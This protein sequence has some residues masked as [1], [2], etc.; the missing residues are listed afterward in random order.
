MPEV[1]GDPLAISEDC[2]EFYRLRDARTA[3]YVARTWAPQLSVGVVI[4]SAAS[5][6]V[7][8]QHLLL[9]LANMLARVHRKIVFE[10]PDPNRPLGV[11]CIIPAST[12]GEALL[13]STKVIDP[14][15]SF[16]LGEVNSCDVTLGIGM[17]RDDRI[18]WHLGANR[19][20]AHL[21]REPVP[22]NL[23]EQGSMRG[24]GLAACL[25]AAVAFKAELGLTSLPR[26]LSAWNYSE[27]S[28]AAIGPEAIQVLHVGR[29]LMVGAGA[30]ASSL[31]YWLRSWGVDGEWAV[32]DADVVKLHNTNRGLLFLP[33]QARWPSGEPQ[34]K[35]K[36][37]AAMLPSARSVEQWYDEAEEMQEQVCDV[38]LGL[39]NDRNVR[40]FLAHRNHTVL[41]HATTGRNWLSQ[42]HRQVAGQDDCIFCRVGEIKEPL[43]DC[44]TG[45][46]PPA[47]QHG[48]PVD[49]ALPF[50]SAASGL[51]LATLLQRLQAGLLLESDVNNWRWDF[52]SDCRMATA[53]ISRCRDG[54]QSWYPARARKKINDGTRWAHLD[55]G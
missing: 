22:L 28:E 47:Q 23:A 33:S 9:S 31:V 10:V 45:S 40:H 3:T 34:S 26:Q 2:S 25:G 27:G 18:Q 8:G 7:V 32:V 12:I 30:V 15:G 52:L 29:T 6:S 51:M 44:S 48:E 49:A 1:E 19:S 37:L 38:V 16:A 55:P 41:L 4:E 5:G 24:A 11:F 50:L 43:F 39:A 13:R 20:L 36:V 14:C 46:V 42:L 54:C 21:A 53:G 17:D 35:A